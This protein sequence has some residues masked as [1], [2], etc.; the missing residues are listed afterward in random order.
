MKI[1]LSRARAE[2]RGRRT[3]ALSAGDHYENNAV[4]A[5]LLSFERQ[6][7]EK[8]GKKNNKKF[9]IHVIYNICVCVCNNNTSSG[10]KPRS[11]HRPVQ[12]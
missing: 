9:Y 7:N 12:F 11:D 4:A 1:S 8:K 6:G 3:R 10:R 5:Q 2:T